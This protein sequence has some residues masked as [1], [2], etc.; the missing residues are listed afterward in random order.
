VFLGLLAAGT[1]RAACRLGLILIAIA[2]LVLVL[3]WSQ[4]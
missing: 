4:L 3:V 1:V 2:F